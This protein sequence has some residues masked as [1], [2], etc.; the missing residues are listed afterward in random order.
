MKRL[1]LAGVWTVCLLTAVPGGA[2]S[3]RAQVPTAAPV[4]STDAVPLF[5][6]FLQ[7]GSSLVS[8]GEFARLEDSVVFSMPTSASAD[9]PQL[10]LINI[11]SD[12][13]DWKRT[14]DYAESVRSSRYLATRAQADY[15]LLSTEVA[16]ALNDVGQ[17]ADPAA[18][19][20][21]VERARRTLAEWPAAH[22]NYKRDEI[23]Q[24]LNTL[25]EAIA[26]LKAASGASTFDLTFVAAGAAP[27]AAEPIIPAPGVRETIEQTLRAAQL[28]R[29]AAERMSL[30]TMAANALDVDAAALPAE[31]AEATR[32]AVTAQIARELEVDRRY[33]ALSTRMLRLATTRARAADVRG[34]QRVFASIR[35]NDAA[36]GGLRPEA[37]AAMSA[38]VEAQLEAARVLRLERDSWALRV[39]ALRAY[40]EAVAGPLY[41][42]QRVAP[43]L[44]DIKALAGSGPD[45]I[46]SI[47]AASRRARSVL[48]KVTP[49]GELRPLH[50]MLVSALQLA[51][52]AAIIRRE[53]AINA[54]MARAW[55]ASSAAAGA[56]MLAQRARVDLQKALQPPQLG[57]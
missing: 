37:V 8:Y 53:A 31:W 56:L 24:M 5:R 48:A 21:I 42:L 57:R 30:L 44:E 35:A 19:L 46:A 47:L 23:Q 12:R 49:P 39:P 6:V 55:D 34:V 9:V 28:T 15:E 54:S 41:R 1:G 3:A 36:L 17:A 22:Y 51:E 4:A 20:A 38:A 27:D 13:V 7:D 2:V 43:L 14:L 10:Q 45:A 16:Q 52:N 18:R 33:Q 32:A 11:P 50:D 29:S 40:R 26:D 25:D